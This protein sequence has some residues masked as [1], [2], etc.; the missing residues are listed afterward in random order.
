LELA[1]TTPPPLSKL[2]ADI[3]S[4]LVSGRGLVPNGLDTEPREL[5]RLT[6]LSDGDT[7]L[8]DRAGGGGRRDFPLPNILPP[9]IFRPDMVVGCDSGRN[10]LH[11]ADL[12]LGG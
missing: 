2:T 7:K 6:V 10:K 5:G 1:A 9:P 11:G 8:D 4:S 12:G 3:K